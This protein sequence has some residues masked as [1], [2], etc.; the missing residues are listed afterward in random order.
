[1]Q[2]I[3]EDLLA[4]IDGIKAPTAHER[5]EQVR[6]LISAQGQ[7]VLILMRFFV[8]G[9]RAQFE[10]D[11]AMASLGPV[12]GMLVAGDSSSAT[13]IDQT[14]SCALEVATSAL[15]RQ[16]CFD[17]VA[18]ILDVERLRLLIGG[19]PG[20]TIVAEAILG[21]FKMALGIAR[22]KQ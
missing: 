10:A 8:T 14:T 21:P 7:C 3:A 15:A 17:H 2:C 16:I 6:K 20:A 13:G 12:L 19:G 18:G 5:F 11:P 9:L 4:K 1:M 22:T